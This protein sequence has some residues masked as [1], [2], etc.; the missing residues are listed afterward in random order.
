MRIHFE[1]SN[2]TNRVMKN[3][4]RRNLPQ[5][6]LAQIE[7]ATNIK[8]D[9]GRKSRVDHCKADRLRCRLTNAKPIWPV[10]VPNGERLNHQQGDQVKSNIAWMCTDSVM[11]GS[12]AGISDSRSASRK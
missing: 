11:E 5:A 4:D 1:Q 12:K 10:L 2:H 7:A 6:V 8:S 9:Q 3:P